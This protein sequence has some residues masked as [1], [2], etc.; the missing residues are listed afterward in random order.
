MPNQLSKY[1][2]RIIKE[3]MKRPFYKID[4]WETEKGVS[5][6]FLDDNGDY[7][8]L[9]YA[10]LYCIY[11]KTDKG[12]ECLYVGK[13]D[14]GIYGR[15]NRWA[16]GVAGKLRAD[17]SHS[18]AKKARLEGVTLKDILLVKTIDSETIDRL[19]D[20]YRDLWFANLDEWIAPLLKS[21]YNTIVYEEQ[22]SLED[23]FKE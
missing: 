15:V 4:A 7:V 8:N 1:A 19:I 22:A 14:H 2:K 10:G 5:T 11:R 23:F 3:G 12:L 20:D 16:K 18:A 13:T 17:E 21:K 9:N 6:L